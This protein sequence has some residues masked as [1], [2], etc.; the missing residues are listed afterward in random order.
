M[1]FH[2]N[3]HEFIKTTTNIYYNVTNLP[4]VTRFCQSF[5][6]CTI[7]LIKLY[8]YYCLN[9]D[10]WLSLNWWEQNYVINYTYVKLV[11]LLE[12]VFAAQEFVLHPAT[13]ALSGIAVCWK[14][15]GD[16]IAYRCVF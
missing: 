14:A 5:R 11:S 4:L 12:S 6:R 16:I 10:L 8:A 3:K 1:L 13:S 15:M 2:F 7:V 9:K